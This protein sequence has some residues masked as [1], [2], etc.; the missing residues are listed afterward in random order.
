MFLAALKKEKLLFSEKCFIR[1][2]SS[3]LEV[4]GRHNFEFFEPLP[5]VEYFSV[6]QS[7]R[8]NSQM[9]GGNKATTM[10]MMNLTQLLGRENSSYTQRSG[11]SRCQ[12][13]YETVSHCSTAQNAHWNSWNLS[14]VI[15]T[16]YFSSD[17][18][19]LLWQQ[20]AIVEKLGKLVTCC[21]RLQ[22]KNLNLPEIN[23]T[24]TRKTWNPFNFTFFSA[25]RSFVVGSISRGSQLDVFNSLQLSARVA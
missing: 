5:S 17:M 2:L 24:R 16:E 11:E 12:C 13:T 4:F 20:F 7:N 18:L 3:L 9:W 23:K 21:R 14:V 15:K 10:M 6:R 8:K 25:V 19:A 1:R 22:P